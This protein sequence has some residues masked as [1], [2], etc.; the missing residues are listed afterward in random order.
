[1]QVLVAAPARCL[2]LWDCLGQNGLLLIII[3]FIIMESQSASYLTTSLF[4][5]DCHHLSDCSRHLYLLSLIDVGE[6]NAGWMIA[7]QGFVFP[8]LFPIFLR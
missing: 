8:N 5:V 4:G 7:L 1:M 6:P 2:S 3:L